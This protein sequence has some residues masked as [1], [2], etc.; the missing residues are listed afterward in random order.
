[1]IRQKS[2]L[3]KLKTL[4]FQHE[5]YFDG[6]FVS[7]VASTN[8]FVIFLYLLCFVLFLFVCLFVFNLYVL[9]IFGIDNMQMV[10]LI[11]LSIEETILTKRR[12]NTSGE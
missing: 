8:K 9:S 6:T 2:L 4:A 10:R 11:Y 1:M 7:D 3:A 12:L 5:L